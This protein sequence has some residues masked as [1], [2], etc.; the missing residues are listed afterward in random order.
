MPFVSILQVKLLRFVSK[1]VDEE[2]WQVLDRVLGS[3]DSENV[4]GLCKR[5]RDIFNF[6]QAGLLT[7]SVGDPLA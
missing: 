7:F 3:P 1:T 5:F 6:E 4:D 2:E